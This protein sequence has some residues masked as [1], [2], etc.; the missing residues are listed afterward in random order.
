MMKDPKE[1]HRVVDI[2][3]KTGLS[4]GSIAYWRKKVPGFDKEYVAALKKMKT[5]RKDTPPEERHPNFKT[6]W[7]KDF[8]DAFVSTGRLA[9]SAALAGVDKDTVK[10]RIDEMS[11]TYDPEFAKLFKKAQSELGET[12]EDKAFERALEKESDTM[13]KHLLAVHLP[14]KHGKRDGP[15]TVNIQFNVLEERGRKFL[16]EIFQPVIEAEIVSTAETKRIPADL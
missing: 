13:L 2:L 16:E 15:Q 10:N 7:E 9:Y 6:G 4:A 1:P 5:K 8:L 14:E 3:Q 12:L 11:G